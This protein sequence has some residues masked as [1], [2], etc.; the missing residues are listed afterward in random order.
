MLGYLCLDIICSLKLTVFL[1][2]RS[3]KTFHFSEQVM[4]VDKYSSI[5][6][7]QME[8]VVDIFS[9]QMEAIVVII[10][11]IFFA[12]RAVLKIENI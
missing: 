3:R 8:A 4:S 5:F 9:H 11:R 6:S 10:L 12:A 1:E 7:R 2:L